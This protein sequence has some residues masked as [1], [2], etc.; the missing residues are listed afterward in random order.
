M[1]RTQQPF[2]AIA[3]AVLLSLRFAAT[4]EPEKPATSVKRG[5]LTEAQVAAYANRVE[6]FAKWPCLAPDLDWRTALADWLAEAE[7]KWSQGFEE[8]IIRDALRDMK[9]GFYLDV[10]C[11][12]PR[13]MNTSYYLEENLHWTG[14]GVDANPTYAEAWRKTRPNS[15]F[16]SFAITDTDGEKVTFYVGQFSSLDK[17]AAEGIAWDGNVVEIRTTTITL[18]TLLERNGVEKIDFLSMD[19]ER[20]ETPA[21]KGFDIQRYRPDLCCIECLV[22]G[23]EE[24]EAW[25]LEYFTSNGYEWIE[26][27]RKADKVNLYYRPAMRK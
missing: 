21:L 15:K 3:I 5:E 23:E 25:L 12:W 24:K 6:Y 8:L 2:A 4:Q 18:N 11:A 17:K 1:S 7:P 19:I 10:G 16:L 13:T 27:Y 14:I 9:G 22:V 26:K 20:Y